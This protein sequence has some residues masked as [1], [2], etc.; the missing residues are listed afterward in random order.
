MFDT[1][2]YCVCVFLYLLNIYRK[3]NK[4]TIKTTRI[5]KFKI[6]N[7]KTKQIFKQQ[8]AHKKQN[9]PTLTRSTN[10]Q[11]PQ[12]YDCFSFLEIRTRKT[13]N[14]MQTK[15][16]SILLSYRSNPTH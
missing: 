14:I 5:F 9:K 3:K 13:D 6:N 7:Y 2:K 4:I 15:R 1:K 8:T 10:K 11:K 16:E 12:V